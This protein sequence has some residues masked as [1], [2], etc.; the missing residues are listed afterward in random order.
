MAHNHLAPLLS[1]YNRQIECN[2]TKFN[3]LYM[4]QFHRVNLQV[5]ALGLLAVLSQSCTKLEDPKPTAQNASTNITTSEAQGLFLRN[6]LAEHTGN[7]LVGEEEPSFSIV[8]HLAWQ[9]AVLVGQGSEQLMLV[10]LASDAALFANS[11]YTGA[12]YVVVTRKADNTLEGN[13]VE[14]L[15]RRRDAPVDTTALFTQLYQN[16]R[17]GIWN[18]SIQGDGLVSVYTADYE[19]LVGKRFRGGIWDK[20]EN[21]LVVMSRSNNAESTRAESTTDDGII[22]NLVQG[23]NRCT[24]WYDRNGDYITTTGDCGSGGG[25]GAGTYTGGGGPGGSPT[26][27][28]GYGGHGSPVVVGCP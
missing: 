16:Y 7:Q 20:Q 27:S 6:S 15:A 10:P 5:A 4:M 25:G 13:L 18:A 11:D 23:G 17:S 26:G 24:D 2:V 21:E 19:Y 3:T 1:V 14:L 12:R 9:R 28:G 22:A 8:D